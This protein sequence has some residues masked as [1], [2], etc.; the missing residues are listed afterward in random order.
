MYRPSMGKYSASA[1]LDRADPIAANNYLARTGLSLV[2]TRAGRKMGANYSDRRS[3]TSASK[4]KE[5]AM[6]TVDKEYIPTH[7][8][9]VRK[10]N[11]T[12]APTISPKNLL[13]N[14]ESLAEWKILPHIARLPDK[15]SYN[16][17]YIPNS[18]AI[19]DSGSRWNTLLIENCKLSPPRNDPKYSSR[20]TLRKSTS[21]EE[22][23]I[24]SATLP[25]IE[26]NVDPSSRSSKKPAR[27]SEKNIHV[28]IRP[29]PGTSIRL[30]PESPNNR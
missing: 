30:A 15:V 25:G 1:V 16:R 17:R 8:S 14:T 21:R 3:A 11:H 13:R 7:N 26:S 20:S 12:R 24:H 19:E 28:A 5:E 10:R 4:T 27:N 29:V 6:E 23:Y 9:L 2:R 18:L 22:E